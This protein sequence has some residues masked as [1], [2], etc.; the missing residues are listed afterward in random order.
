MYLFST[1]GYEFID[2]PLYIYICGGLDLLNSYVKI[3]IHANNY[4]AN[5]KRMLL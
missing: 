1:R 5:A 4:T 3:F 2:V